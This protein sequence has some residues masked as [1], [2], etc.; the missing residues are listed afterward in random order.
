MPNRFNICEVA[1]YVFNVCAVANDAERS[2]ASRRDAGARQYCKRVVA[3]VKLLWQH[4]AVAQA[5]PVPSCQE[6]RTAACC[7]QSVKR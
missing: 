5:G 6:R 4:W 3:L 7:A 1:Y 2:A